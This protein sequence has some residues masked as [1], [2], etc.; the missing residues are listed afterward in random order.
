MG[1]IDNI[2]TLKGVF[3]EDIWHSKAEKGETEMIISNC[4]NVFFDDFDF[5]LT[6]YRCYLLEVILIIYA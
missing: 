1:K 6:S 2:L 5:V 4:G 3:L